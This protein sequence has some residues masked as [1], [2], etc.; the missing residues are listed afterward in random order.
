V[1]LDRAQYARNAVEIRA[2]SE[3]RI[4]EESVRSYERALTSAR[5]AAQQANEVL[6]ISTAAFEVGATTNIEVIDAQR[7]ARDAET[8]AEV[9]EDA[10]RRARLELLVAIGRFPL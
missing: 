6:K 9:A 10:L 7:S 4:G 2:R 5:L 8:L 3:I 1:A